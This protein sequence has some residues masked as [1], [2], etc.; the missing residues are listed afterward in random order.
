MNLTWASFLPTL[1]DLSGLF[2][3]EHIGVGAQ[4]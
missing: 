4:T 1:S 3:A 2:D